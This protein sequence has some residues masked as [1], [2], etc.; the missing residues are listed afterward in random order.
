[1]RTAS[2]NALASVDLAALRAEIAALR[3]L[4]EQ[5]LPAPLAPREWLS[6]EQAAALALRSPQCIRAWCRD[7]RIGTKVRG[8][9]QI[10]RAQMRR[11]VI[12]RF[13]EGRLPVPMRNG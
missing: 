9:W 6:V 13:G 1:M 2:S 5:R 12:E 10:D 4:I 3:E 11:L 8:V 7:R